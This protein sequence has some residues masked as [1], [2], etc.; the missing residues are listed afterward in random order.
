MS[1]KQIVVFTII[2]VAIVVVA[3]F[4]LFNQK[5]MESEPDLRQE[6]ELQP[7]LEHNPYKEAD[8]TI[9]VIPAPNDTYGY[10]IKMNGRILI[11]QPNAPALPGMEGFKTEEVA[12]KVGEFVIYK[13]RQN[14]FPPGVSAAELDSLDVLRD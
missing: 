7:E 2:A 10:N 3:Y 6:P 4:F 11:H 13:I 14:I 9:K 1:V 12:L 5:I 8:L